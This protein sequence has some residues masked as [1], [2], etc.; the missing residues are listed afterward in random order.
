MFHSLTSKDAMSMTDARVESLEAT[1]G[2]L[3]AVLISF[4]AFKYHRSAFG[5]KAL[6]FGRV[7][8]AAIAAAEKASKRD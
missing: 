7:P 3:K 4:R 8:K 1:W 6:E 2:S 5:S